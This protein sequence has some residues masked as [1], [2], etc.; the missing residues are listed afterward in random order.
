MGPCSG[1]CEGY[2][3]AECWA[4]EC[5]KP[6]FEGYAVDFEGCF[7]VWWDPVERKII[8]ECSVVKVGAVLPEAVVI[9]KLGHVFFGGCAS[10]C[11]L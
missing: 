11:G 2:P 1:G 5:D 6:I 3:G 9:S 4:P 10:V 8:E 7:G